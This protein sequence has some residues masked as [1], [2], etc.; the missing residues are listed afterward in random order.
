MINKGTESQNRND[1]KKEIKVY[2]NFRISIHFG[3]SLNLLAL[4]AGLFLIKNISKQCK[5]KKSK[6]SVDR[7]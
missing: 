5:T 2:N 1:N 3:D 4:I 6:P 7:K